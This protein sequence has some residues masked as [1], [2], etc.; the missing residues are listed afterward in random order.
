MPKVE[1]I[2][3]EMQR[4]PKGIRFQDLCIVCDAI[5]VRLATKAAAIDSIRLPGQAIHE[6]IS[7]MK[8]VWQKHIR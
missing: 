8:R 5:L 1:D 6:S 3:K 2:L 4:N 7:K